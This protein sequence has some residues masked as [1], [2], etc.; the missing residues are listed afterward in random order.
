MR[1]NDARQYTQELII[2]NSGPKGR[3]QHR[4]DHRKTRDI[5]NER[6]FAGVVVNAALKTAVYTRSD[7]VKNNCRRQRTDGVKSFN[8]ALWRH[9]PESVSIA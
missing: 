5:E 6:V 3:T 4:I 8:I 1:P 9:S 7:R 2:D